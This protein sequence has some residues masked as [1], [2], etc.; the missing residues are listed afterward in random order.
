MRCDSKDML[1]GGDIGF[2]V[3]FTNV[4][5]TLEEVLKFQTISKEWRAVRGT[6]GGAECLRADVISRASG[7]LGTSV[8]SRFCT[9]SFSLSEG[10]FSSMGVRILEL[11]S[12]VTSEEE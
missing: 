3:Y 8:I 9:E 5:R 6:S 4:F 10:A 1:K 11:E 12:P 2:R 7:A